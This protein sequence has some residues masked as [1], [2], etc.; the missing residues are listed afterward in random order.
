MNIPTF[1]WI[2][3]IIILYLHFFRKCYESIME[4]KEDEPEPIPESV[5]HMYS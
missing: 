2:N 5:R 4:F 1:V 3:S